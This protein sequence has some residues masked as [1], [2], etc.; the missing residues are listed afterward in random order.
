MEFHDDL[1]AYHNTIPRL[2]NQHDVERQL[3][4]NQRTMMDLTGKYLHVLDL[5]SGKFE[6]KIIESKC[7]YEGKTPLACATHKKATQWKA[8]N[9]FVSFYL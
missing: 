5:K 2:L 6:S 8:I 4:M 7:K 1:G 9:P 3:K